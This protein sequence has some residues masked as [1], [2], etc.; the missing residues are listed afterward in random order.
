MS[1]P[2]KS[3]KSTK[4]VKSAQSASGRKTKKTTGS[5]TQVKK[6]SVK[7]STVRKSSHKRYSRDDRKQVMK[8]I[9][10]LKDEEDYNNI[11]DIL[12]ED[13]S[14]VWTSNSA[15][16]FIDLSIVHNKTLDKIE[17]YLNKVDKKNQKYLDLDVDV[18]PQSTADSSDRTYRLSNYEQN[19]IKQR[20]LNSNTQSVKTDAKKKTAKSSSKN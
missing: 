3:T 4:S 11:F 2:H 15:G 14:N 20:R 7:R 13:E 1:S 19:I 16:V 17:K 6:T 8:R 5:K 12:N 10:S 9:E 18:L